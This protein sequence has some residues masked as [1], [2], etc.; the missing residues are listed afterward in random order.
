M[1]HVIYDRGIRKRPDA[2]E[3]VINEK[4]FVIK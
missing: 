2:P 4:I 1:S 3:F